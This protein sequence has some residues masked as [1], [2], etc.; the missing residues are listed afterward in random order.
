MEDLVEEAWVVEWVEDLE[1]E[2]VVDSVEV[3][4]PQGC[5]T[6]LL[7][8]MDSEQPETCQVNI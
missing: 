1:E 7:S 5:Q 2:W 3:S 8:L 6:T 4:E